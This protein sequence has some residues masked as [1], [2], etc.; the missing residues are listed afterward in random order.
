MH[1]I[2]KLTAKEFYA[3]HYS[4]VCHNFLDYMEFAEAYANAKRNGIKGGV[5]S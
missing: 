1:G 2:E 5:R 4:K 3:K